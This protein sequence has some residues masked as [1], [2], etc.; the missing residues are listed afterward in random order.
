MNCPNEG[1]IIKDKA[2]DFKVFHTTITETVIFNLPKI[3]KDYFL[4][5]CLLLFIM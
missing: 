3:K 5:L 4:L 2:T 1:T